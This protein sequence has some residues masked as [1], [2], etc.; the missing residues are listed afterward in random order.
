MNIALQ[1][2]T[3]QTFYAC[4]AMLA[5][6][7]FEMPL[8][9]SGVMLRSVISAGITVLS[10]DKIANEKTQAVFGLTAAKVAL[11]GIIWFAQTAI[12]YAL[13]YAAPPRIHEVFM[14]GF[15]ISVMSSIRLL[16]HGSLF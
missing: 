10:Y 9:I 3:D 4:G 11:Y 5:H 1:P 13:G 8:G 14:A 15:G 7:A 6:W 12:L 2:L 16:C